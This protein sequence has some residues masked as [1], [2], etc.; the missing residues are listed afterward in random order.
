MHSLERLETFARLLH[1][2]QRVE[3]VS[4]RPD[5]REMTTT[6]EHT[7][8]VVMLSWYIMS[9]HQLPLNRERVFAYALAHDLIEAYAGDTF[10]YDAAARKTKVEREEKALARIEA[11]FPEFSD[12]TQT[13]HEYEHRATPEARFVYAVDKLVD[14]LNASMEE[15]QSIWKEFGISFADLLEH[16]TDKIAQSEH[17]LPYWNLL[18]EKLKGKRDF[19][20]DT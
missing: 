14:P 20:F 17:V 18:V 16:K 15:T 4:R 19:F 10:L 11:E 3:R 2:V 12:L 9:T 6:A 8:E 1:A 5:E 7:F 13:I